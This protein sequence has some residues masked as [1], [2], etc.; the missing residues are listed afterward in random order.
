MFVFNATLTVVRIRT[1]IATN[2]RLTGSQ[3][4]ASAVAATTAAAADEIGTSVTEARALAT[5]N[6]AT[7]RSG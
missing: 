6:I 2:A 4:A 3:R 5:A 1:T 7:N